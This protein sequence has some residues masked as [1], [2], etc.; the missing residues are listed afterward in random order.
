[1]LGPGGVD[2]E[3]GVDDGQ[4]GDDLVGAQRPIVVVGLPPQGEF[5]RVPG[6]QPI[7]DH[8]ERGG[9]VE[10]EIQ[11]VG[12]EQPQDQHELD[13]EAHHRECG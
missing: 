4:C 6:G 7:G 12:D 3:R 1:V 8:R 5:E 10:D 13:V 2:Q 9:Q 11:C